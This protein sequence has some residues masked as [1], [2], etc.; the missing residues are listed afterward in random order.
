MTQGEDI[1][2]RSSKTTMPLAED[3]EQ[4]KRDTW[5]SKSMLQFIKS[6][7]ST[8]EGIWLLIALFAMHVSFNAHFLHFLHSSS[9]LWS[10]P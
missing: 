2:D 8:A 6:R 4:S 5:S 1:L 7:K 3:Y 10:L 9:D